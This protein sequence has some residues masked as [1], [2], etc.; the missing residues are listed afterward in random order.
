[1][2]PVLTTEESPRVRSRAR[3]VAARAGT[4]LAAALLLVI[5]IVPGEPDHLSP[6]VLLRIPI[7]GLLG[8]GIVLAVPV[9]ARTVV[10]AAVGA[11]IGLWGAVRVVDVGFFST[12]DRPFDPVLDWGFVSSGVTVLRQSMGGAAAL[13]I[14][15]VALLA[16]AALAAVGAT[17]GVRLSRAAARHRG[18][19]AAVVAVLGLVWVACALTGVRVTGEPVA[20][21]DLLDRAGQVRISLN[22]SEDFAA[23]LTSDAYH[24]MPG[25]Q[26]LTALRG[27]DVLLVLVESYGR[28]A[29]EN[30]EISPEVDAVLADGTRRLAA[31]GFGSA[32]AFLTS[33]TVGGG[34]WLASATLLSGT[35]VD[36]QQRYEHLPETD[37]T[38]LPAAFRRAGWHTAAVMPGLNSDWPEGRYYG[39]DRI[40]GAHDLGYAGPV[41]TFDSVPDQYVLSY[42]E[43]T[44]RSRAE[45]VMAVVPLIS[46]HAPWSPVPELLDWNEIGDGSGYAQPA[47]SLNPAEIIL[48]R[49]VS[50]VRADYARAISYSLTTLVSYVE[51]YGDDDLVLIFVGDHQPAPVVIGDTDNHDT[52]ISIV[53]RDPSVLARVAEWGWTTGLRPDPGSPVWP[54]DE[55]RDRFL[56][57]FA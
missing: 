17:A 6:P 26:L 15:V 22:D 18:R 9:R 46:S 32:S 11:V 12:L 38:T 36:N 48:Q 29:L 57:A 44:E 30:P 8:L 42:V 40:V 2:T 28:V 39:Y 41:F 1:M 47:E 4:V 52:P 34:S 33:P 21:R 14:V 23:S 51:T 56:D 3:A 5:L 50:R 43:H 25:T 20:A 16:V 31:A 35:W 54:M 24:D 27:K 7:E 10:A 37:R 55:F 13:G 49:D 19:T 45:P 53:A